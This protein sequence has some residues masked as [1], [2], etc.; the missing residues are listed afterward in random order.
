VGEEPDSKIFNI[1]EDT[2]RTR[3]PFFEKALSGDWKEKNE[4]MVQLPTAQPAAFSMYLD[5]I[6]SDCICLELEDES[7]VDPTLTLGPA[8]VLGDIL[9]D[10]DFRDAIVD[11][12][13]HHATHKNQ[14]P[15]ELHQY[16]FENTPSD[17]PLQKLL[18]DLLALRGRAAWLTESSEGIL[19]EKALF[20]VL[21]VIFRRRELQTTQDPRFQNGVCED[22]HCHVKNNTTCYRDKLGLA[23]SI[24]PLVPQEK[25]NSVQT[26]SFGSAGSH[27][28]ASVTNSKSFMRGFDGGQCHYFPTYNY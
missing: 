2:L 28:S 1:Y 13:I 19:T 7:L 14:H 20:E 9:L 11:A 18:T 24:M 17:W 15:F 4:R 8:Y 12:I 27:P 5:F 23:S 16:V 26:P 3:S 22:Y 21:K 25:I 10:H 6:H